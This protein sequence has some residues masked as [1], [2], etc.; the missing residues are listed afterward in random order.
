M[1]TY[2][3]VEAFYPWITGEDNG[4]LFGGL[5]KDAPEK[6]VAAYNDYVQEN[7]KQMAQNLIV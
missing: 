1:E 6:A 5:R 7:E 2:E 4:Q 3:A